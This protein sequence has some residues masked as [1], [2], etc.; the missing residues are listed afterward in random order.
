MEA[1]TAD[2]SP[3]KRQLV[4]IDYK[5]CIICQNT[6]NK[7]RCN[8][9]ID[10]F[11]N[12]YASIGDS[13][14]SPI[15]KRLHFLTAE[16]LIKHEAFCHKDC[17]SKIGNER[18]Y[19]RAK[20]RYEK[21]TTHKDVALISPKRG[22][23][24]TDVSFSVSACASSGSEP[25][26]QLRSAAPPYNPD[27]CIICPKEGGVLH[28]VMTKEKR[29]KL[30]RVAAKLTDRNL[31]IRLNTLSDPTDAVANDV[32]CHQLCWIYAQRDAQ[33]PKDKVLNQK[34]CVMPLSAS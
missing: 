26:K 14:V 31:F 34:H 12:N 8:P 24:S 30:L 11:I 23:P 6:N 3:P 27:H 25:P 10:S 20:T 15:H 29:L 33:P 21:A 5:A 7:Q 22:R 9:Q 18:N 13:T 16:H 28:K 19:Q 4:E 32:Q 17:Y 1:I 2:A